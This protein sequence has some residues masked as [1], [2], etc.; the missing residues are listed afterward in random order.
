MLP[1][2]DVV[3]ADETYY[4]RTK[5]KKALSQFRLMQSRVLMSVFAVAFG[6]KQTSLP[7]R[8]MSGYGPYPTSTSALHTSAFGSK[9]DMTLC[10]NPL[11]RLLFGG[12][13]DMRY[14]T[15]YVR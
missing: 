8:K 11:S 9:A 15:A 12:K 3:E 1:P 6:V 10:G 5:E 4:G 13:A 2:L 14:C 7:R